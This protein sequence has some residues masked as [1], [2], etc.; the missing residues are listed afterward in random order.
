MKLLKTICKLIKAI[1]GCDSQL[2]QDFNTFEELEAWFLL[3]TELRLP[4]PNLCDDYSRQSRA[5]AEV[6]GY[7]LSC[8]LV[9]DGIAY[10]T[11]V[12]D[13]GVFH[14][15]NTAIVTETQEV[16]YVDLAWNKL[17]KLCTFY[18]GGKF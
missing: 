17:I 10:T 6:D 14:I 9:A 12:M 3:H 15:G 5:L 8:C 1:G 16:Y 18:K 4:E 7:F 2:L 13:K 11:Q